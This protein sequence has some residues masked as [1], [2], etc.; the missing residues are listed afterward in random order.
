MNP[1]VRGLATFAALFLGACVG[2]P[3]GGP[4]EVERA[5]QSLGLSEETYAAPAADWWQALGDPQLDRLVAQ[6][7]A[8]NPGLAASLARVRVAWEQA[9][10]VG[11]GDKPSIDFDT[12]LLRQRASENYIYPPPYAGS[13]F[14]DARIGLNLAWSLDFWGQQSALIRQAESSARATEFDSVGALLALSGAVS[15]TYVDLRRVSALEQ[16]A[17]HSI[18][19]RQRIVELTQR[20]VEAGL[21]SEI[22]LK[23]AEASRAQAEVEREQARMGGELAVHALAALSGQGAGAYATIAAPT[24]DLEKAL[25]LPDSL[26]A[27]LLAHRP[28]VAAAQARVTAATAGRE[29]A[30]AAFY[31]NVNLIGFAGY[32]ALAIDKLPQGGSHTWTVG[33]ALHLPLFDAGRLKAEYGRAAADLDAAIA[34]YNDT[35]LRAVRECADQASRVQSLDRQL[36]EQQPGLEAAERAFALADQ[37]YGAGLASYLAVLNA[38][39]QLLAARRQRINL[40]ADRTQAR[41]ALLVALG[42]SFDSRHSTPLAAVGPSPRKESTP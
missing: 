30:R 40:L 1:V 26:P 42:G 41:V 16:I 36:A 10:V 9:R 27:D 33:P 32:A 18:Q 4:H 19:Q 21:D 17:E 14:W 31:P 2:T 3:P 38:E 23:S 20:R 25:P 29:A 24:M 5:P 6:A 37:R 7:L 34:S 39:T 28:D 22:E 13:T 11:A 35:V 12:S 8:G 15:Q